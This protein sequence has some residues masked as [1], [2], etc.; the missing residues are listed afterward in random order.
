MDRATLLEKY[1]SHAM[2]LDRDIKRFDD[3]GMS[4]DTPLHLAAMNNA[5]RDVEFMLHEVPSV[6]VLGDIGNTPLHMA[7]MFG[8]AAV[9]DV[10]LRHG[11]RI[12]AENE[13]GDKPLGFLRTN[14]EEVMAVVRKYHPEL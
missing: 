2:F 7:V 14:S 9:V 12:D 10:L 4:E 8:S 1:R 3:H 11:A 13:Y 6:D 5:A